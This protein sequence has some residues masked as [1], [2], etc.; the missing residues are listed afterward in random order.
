MEEWSPSN[1]SINSSPAPLCVFAWLARQRLAGA[2]L[3]LASGNNSALQKMT[4][5]V[6]GLSARDWTAGEGI[7]PLSPGNILVHC[8]AP[9]ATG[10]KK[11]KPNPLWWSGRQRSPERTIESQFKN[12][13]VL[14]KQDHFLS[15]S[16][17]PVRIVWSPSPLE[18]VGSLVPMP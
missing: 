16:V 10:D 1:K 7:Q 12:K 14:V 11:Q 9:W 17:L 13:S 18:V 15:E 8:P 2:T 3:P 4:L 6:T 5:Q